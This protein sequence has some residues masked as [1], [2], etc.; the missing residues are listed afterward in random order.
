VD[1]DVI[2]TGIEYERP[3]SKREA[4]T[5]GVEMT[6]PT[7]SM[8]ESLIE[9]LSSYNISDKSILYRH[10]DSE[11]QGHAVLRPG[12]ADAAV[13]V[14]L[15]GETVGVA[16]GIG[17]SPRIGP[18]DPYLGGVWAVVEAVRNVACVGGTPL[19]ITDC[20]N[21][22][23]PEDPEVFWDFSE[24]VRGVGEACKGLRVAGD[25]AHPIPVVSGN[26]SFYNQSGNGRPIA[27]SPI[28]ACAGRVNDASVSRS[29]GFKQPGSHIVL[30]GLLHDRIGGSEY[31]KRFLPGGQFDAPQPDFVRESAM[32]RAL[33]EGV[34]N[35]LILAAHDISHG[36]LAVAVAEMAIESGPL[37][38]GCEIRLDGHT[39]NVSPVA[40][41]LFSEF[42]G[43]VVEV[44]PDLWPRYR[45]D[46][47]DVRVDWMELGRT[48]ERPVL[49]LRIGGES[50]EVSIETL[51]SA[52]R[53]GKVNPL[54]A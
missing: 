28:V 25:G 13:A 21:Y 52:H 26:V 29:L 24:G 45:K 23:D 22:G 42:G 33:I 16:A 15:P 31:A 12:E 40:H 50:V 3:A 46:L 6:P 2:T 44:S 7:E 37:D 32:I 30:L 20:L 51:R 17:G 8:K 34:E 10:Y 35:R 38:V 27:P 39:S 43:I 9:L 54:F 49:D 48:H 47:E 41:Q 53:G 18:V 11:V 5:G 14:V 4:A 1:V 19:A 36:G